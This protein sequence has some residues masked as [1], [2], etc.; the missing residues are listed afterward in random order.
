M[1]RSSPHFQGRAH[2]FAHRTFKV[3][4][5]P[6]PPP[7][8][9]FAAFRPGFSRSRTSEEVERKK[10][11]VYVNFVSSLA[12]PFR[13]FRILTVLYY[14]NGEKHALKTEGQASSE[15]T[16]PRLFLKFFSSSETSPLKGLLILFSLR[17][18]SPHPALRTLVQ[19]PR[20]RHTHVVRA[21][22]LIYGLLPLPPAPQLR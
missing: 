16:A 15:G 10:G 3:D 20:T 21:L 7:R 12:P 17:R 5:H 18:R 14:F 22:P 2:F 1:P 11:A 19:L 4:K 9:L 8:C 13:T 6:L